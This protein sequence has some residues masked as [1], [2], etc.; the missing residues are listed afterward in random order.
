M[1]YAAIDSTD[2]EILSIHETRGRAQ[3]WCDDSGR[4]FV[5]IAALPAASSA[6]VG[7]YRVRGGVESRV[8]HDVAEAMRDLADE[9]GAMQYLQRHD[10]LGILEHGV[11]EGMPHEHYVY[12]L[13]ALRLAGGRHA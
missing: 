11:P 13:A 1:R 5:R 12:S 8:E 2:G 6:T 9:A 4:L 10:A 3:K 7:D